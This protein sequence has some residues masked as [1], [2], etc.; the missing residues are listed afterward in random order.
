MRAPLVLV[1]LLLAGCGEPA[2]PDAESAEAPGE[3]GGIPGPP[4]PEQ[5]AA[6]A[7]HERRLEAK[8]ACGVVPPA[9][10]GAGD[11]GTLRRDDGSDAVSVLADRLGVEPVPH[12]DTT[13]L[14]GDLQA[15]W[16]G[17]GTYLHLWLREGD[18]SPD[19][20][21]HLF[22]PFLEGAVQED[23][24]PSAWSVRWHDRDRLVTYRL[25]NLNG[26]GG[27]G[28]SGFLYGPLDDRPLIGLDAAWDATRDY[29]ACLEERGEGW[30]RAAWE[31]ARASAD[32]ALHG[33]DGRF[34][35]SL[36][37]HDGDWFWSMH[38]DAEMGGLYA[39]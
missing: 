37:F 17:G 24:N 32:V 13:F 16:M 18:W 11:T 30:D 20:T 38:V 3:P 19:R 23:A 39:T 33:H 8:R 36:S 22:E 5:E 34:L 10:F 14:L 35:Y 28:G 21:R 7:A 12:N 2:T 15:E 25:G 1:L 6:N 4:D 9:Q 29:G 26:Y 31:E 27:G